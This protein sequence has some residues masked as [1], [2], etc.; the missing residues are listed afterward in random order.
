MKGLAKRG[1]II[2]VS[3]LMTILTFLV[4]IHASNFSSQITNTTLESGTTEQLNFTV[5][6]TDPQL[7]ITEVNIT[8]P[9]G[10]S[11]ISESN[12]TSA[13][14]TSFYTVSPN[15]TWTNTTSSGFIQN[16]TEEYF[17]FNV[18][19][20]SGTGTYNFTL[21]VKFTDNSIN[22]TNLT[23]TVLDTIPPA[24]IIPSPP[25][26]ANNSVINADYFEINITFTEVNPDTCILELNNG[27]QANY[28]M[29]ML[30]NYAC[31]FN[32]TNQS[33]GIHY[34]SVYINDTSGHTGWNGTW[35]V[36]LDRQYPLINLQSP[37]NN[38]VINSTRTPSFTFNVTDNLASLL[39]CTLYLKNG[40]ANAYGT[41]SSVLNDTSTTITANTPLINGTY[42]WWITCSDGA[43]ENQSEIRNITID[44]D[45]FPPTNIIPSPPTPANNSYTAKTWILI[46]ITFSEVNPDSC[47]LE[48]NNQTNY[49]MNINKTERYCWY[50]LTN[51]T[52]GIYT[53]SVYVNDTFGNLGWNGSWIAIIETT[54]PSVTITSPVN[55]TNISRSYI[56]ISFTA[57]DAV[58]PTMNCSIY[59]DGNYSYNASVANATPYSLIHTGLT[60]GTTHNITINCS[61]A[62]Y[63]ATAFAVFGVYP[64]L[65]IESI[66]W[67]STGVSPNDN[68][69]TQGSKITITVTVNNTGD[70]NISNNVTLVLKWDGYTNRVINGTYE[71]PAES[72]TNGSK[73]TVIFYDVINTSYV[74]FGSHTITAEIST[75]ESEATTSNNILN[76]ETIVG[77]NITVINSY[78]WASWINSSYPAKVDPNEQV[79]FNISVTYANGEPATDLNISLNFEISETSPSSG[80]TY[81][82]SATGNSSGYYWFNLT[83]PN[84]ANGFIQPGIYTLKLNIT[85]NNYTG[86]SSLT[87]NLTAPRLGS[88]PI[89]LY[90]LDLQGGSSAYQIVNITI[91][92]TGNKPAS[93]IEIKYWTDSNSGV[94][95]SLISWGHCWN[96]TSLGAGKSNSTACIGIKVEATSTGTKHFYINVT[97]RDADSRLYYNYADYTFTVLDSGNQSTTQTTDQTSTNQPSSS[98]SPYAIE[99]TDYPSELIA[100]PGEWVLAKVKV[101]NTGNLSLTAKAT[102]VVPYI[103]SF[104]VT[105]EEKTLAIGEE[106]E[107]TINMS[108]QSDIEV[109]NYI[110]TFKAYKKGNED[111][112]DE[113]A[114]TLKI[115][116]TNETIE[117]IN[118][119]LLNY[120]EEFE[121]LKS[122]L[123]SLKSEKEFENNTNI[124][125][126]KRLITEIEDLLK[127]ANVS[128]TNKDYVTAQSLISLIGDKLNATKELLKPFQKIKGGTTVKG[129][130]E[131]LIWTLIIFIAIIV[132]FFVYYIF[133]S[134]KGYHPK[135]GYKPVKDSSEL[136]KRF[137]TRM[138][139]LRITRKG[140]SKSD[141]ENIPSGPLAYTGDYVKHRSLEYSYTKNFKERIKKFFKREKQKKLWEFSSF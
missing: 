40:T 66:I 72:L 51:L 74:T 11:F 129:T 117:E 141:K 99:I 134:H 96:I 128:L 90:D 31:Y 33:E 106:T 10:F 86:I 64:D 79:F 76:N 138:K 116:P 14:D 65:A 16:G 3:I 7:N 87:F 56:N 108:I 63:T 118:S 95:I 93:N 38:T 36:T 102:V 126:A 137:T 84:L 109:G 97:G 49:T 77:Y 91:S 68:R 130:S 120:F 75:N 78:G 15:L 110:G 132:I 62:N 69:T 42:L 19:V 45:D 124:T 58:A 85:K 101:K 28:T 50:N 103:E 24:N 136:I 104:T 30:G 94:T 107:F 73:Y 125:K 140:A 112:S 100:H 5:N 81:T 26:P 46:N 35:F 67:N 121:S 13:A 71:I 133:L 9:S 6:N 1:R 8:L 53:Y 127:K 29:T 60:P 4:S 111:I 70:F 115:I 32:A 55:N 20:P 113:K 48:W 131:W 88:N 34:Y 139:S 59:I 12:Q 37:A 18:S 105:P 123:E 41:N 47:L 57:T 17:L 119:T 54:A 80:R 61:D 89:G 43:N 92:N 21:T 82:L 122:L 83:A 114:F 39:S 22:S 23:I 27:T 135:Y 52:D 2:T 25:T 98:F 44:V